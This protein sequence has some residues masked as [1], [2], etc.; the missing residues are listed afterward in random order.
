MLDGYE[1]NSLLRSSYGSESDDK[2]EDNLINTPL[3]FARFYTEALNNPES[4][5]YLIITDNQYVFAKNCDD[6][7]QGHML[8]ITKAFLE[9]QGRD[10]NIKVLE[11][12]RIY[13]EFDKNF[14]IFSFEIR[15]DPIHKKIEKVM[16]TMINKSFITP[17][18]YI[19]FKTFCDTYKDVITKCGFTFS[20]WSNTTRKYVPIKNISQLDAYLTTIVDENSKSYKLKDEERIVGVSTNSSNNKIIL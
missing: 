19:S 12:A 1:L 20:I 3:Q 15:K 14:L 13:N 18:E 4:G 5:A 16:R 2:V 10:S 6:G 11:A 17:K 7:K 8:S 9:M